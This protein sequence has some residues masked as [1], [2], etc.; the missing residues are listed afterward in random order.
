MP[1]RPAPPD[2]RRRR[3]ERRALPIIAIA[4]LAL[5]AGLVL[6]ARHVP[7]EQ[8]VA[9]R[10]AEAWRRADYAAMRAELTA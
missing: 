4:A 7:G 10:F 2:S 3:L 9:E 6:G 1:A 5:L 8:R